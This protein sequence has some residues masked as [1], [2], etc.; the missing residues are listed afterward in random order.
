MLCYCDSLGI[1]TTF[2][3]DTL[4]KGDWKA[5]AELQDPESGSWVSL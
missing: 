3:A 1:V 4:T 2:P 5:L